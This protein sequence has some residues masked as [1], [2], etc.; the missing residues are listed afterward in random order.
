MTVSHVPGLNELEELLHALLP[1]E[2]LLGR[3]VGHQPAHDFSP[4]EELSQRRGKVVFEEGLTGFEDVPGH[5]LPVAEDCSLVLLVEGF[6]H[7]VEH[8]LEEG[9]VDGRALRRF[10]VEPLAEEVNFYFGEVHDVLSQGLAEQ[11]RL[12]EGL[13]V[14][15]V[16]SQGLVEVAALLLADGVAVPGLEDD[17]GP[18]HLELVELGDDVVHLVRPVP[19]VVDCQQAELLDNR[20]VGLEGLDFLLRLDWRVVLGRRLLYRL[21]RSG[22]ELL[23]GVDPRRGH[24]FLDLLLLVGACAAQQF[25]YIEQSA[26]GRAH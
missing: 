9:A 10:Q 1:Q 6:L 13:K 7:D 19:E 17:L 15:E 18:E 5:G 11:L 12:L 21:L 3:Q 26:G 22:F 2:L 4:A 25:S 20:E 16:G 23:R 24:Y 14:L 8:E